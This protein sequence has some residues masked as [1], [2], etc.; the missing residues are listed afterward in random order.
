MV[1]T[2]I[3]HQGKRFFKVE[4]KNLFGLRNKAHYVIHY[5]MAKLDIKLSVLYI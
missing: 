5:K 4:F 1:Q 2:S 3:D